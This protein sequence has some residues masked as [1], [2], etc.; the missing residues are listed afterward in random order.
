MAV[1][2]RLPTDARRPSLESELATPFGGVCCETHPAPFS[3]NRTTDD[4]ASKDVWITGSTAT[5]QGRP[6]F[7]MLEVVSMRLESR[8]VAV[9]I[10]TPV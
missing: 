2:R 6:N 1:E 7:R 3:R 5:G 4:F 8:G 9:S 10:T